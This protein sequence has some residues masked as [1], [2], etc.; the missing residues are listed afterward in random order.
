MPS[1]GWILIGLTAWVCYD[2]YVIGRIM[3]DSIIFF[4]LAFATAF[5]FLNPANDVSWANQVLPLLG[6]GPAVPLWVSLGTADWMVKLSLALV[7]LVPYRVL[8]RKVT[9]SVA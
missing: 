1:D 6:V 5:T 7:A 8:L 4:S 2:Y 9:T 3:A